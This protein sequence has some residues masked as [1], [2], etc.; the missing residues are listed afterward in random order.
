MVVVILQKGVHMDEMDSFVLETFLK[1]VLEIL[2]GC[3]DISE[4]KDKIKALLE[5]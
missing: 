2:D 1:M 3:K 5:K 4:A